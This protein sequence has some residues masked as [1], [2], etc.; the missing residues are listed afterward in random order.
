[1]VWQPKFIGN[2]PES[3]ALQWTLH[4]R[5]VFPLPTPD[6]VTVGVVSGLSAWNVFLCPLVLARSPDQ[7]VPTL[8]LWNFQ[9]QYGIGVPGPLAAVVLPTFP[10]LALHL[11]GRRYLLRGPA[12]G[13]G[14]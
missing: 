9:N 11:F 4:P 3:S 14:Q 8:G 13:F 10:V 5:L 1:M 6:L 2:I 12:A 7:R